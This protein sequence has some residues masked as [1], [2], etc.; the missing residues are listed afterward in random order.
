M[1]DVV[2][3]EPDNIAT[4]LTKSLEAPPIDPV[5]LSIAN[6]V[7]AGKAVPDIAESVGIGVDLVA[8]ILEKKEV[9]S[10]MDT[11]MF[12]QG[13]ANRS[14]R[15]A[16]INTVIEGKIQDALE[17][18]VWSKKDLLDWLKHLNDL[19]AAM[20]PKEKGPLVALQVNN[21]DTLMKDL[22]TDG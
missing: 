16:L 22:L 12:N 13:Y 17:T 10:Y 18:G 20:R 5:M 8:Q 11:V 9:K 4:A 19:E 1:S 14:K 15:L 6:D 21:Y 7:L 2:V 3:Y